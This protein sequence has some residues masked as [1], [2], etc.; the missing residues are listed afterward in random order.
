MN[1][2]RIDIPLFSNR[3]MANIKG[4]SNMETLIRQNY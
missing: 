3:I 1:T 2:I 4:T